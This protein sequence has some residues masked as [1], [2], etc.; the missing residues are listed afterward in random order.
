MLRVYKGDGYSLIDTIQ[1]DGQNWH[2][3]TNMVIETTIPVDVYCFDTCG[4]ISSNRIKDGVYEYA[5]NT[6]TKQHLTPS[7][8]TIEVKWLMPNCRYKIES[9]S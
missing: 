2:V 5:G 7:N 9:A 6:H 4:Y 3:E 8:G 1:R